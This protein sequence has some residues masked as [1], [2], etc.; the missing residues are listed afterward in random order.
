MIHRGEAPTRYNS[1]YI[2]QK[3]YFDMSEREQTSEGYTIQSILGEKVGT[4][5]D[6]C[7][8]KAMDHSFALC[9]LVRRSARPLL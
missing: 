3:V 6:D 7:G 1:D 5:S 8:D 9:P 4:E 2:V